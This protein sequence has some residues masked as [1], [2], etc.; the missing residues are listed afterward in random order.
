MQYN[1][2]FIFAVVSMLTLGIANF[3]Y[4]KSSQILGPVNATFYYYLFSFLI[5]TVVWLTFREKQF[6]SKFSY[7]DL[8]WPL[9]IAIFLFSSVLSF[10]YSV[11]YIN[12]SVGSTIRSMS[13][14]VTIVLALLVYKEN[15]AVKDYI[16]TVLALAAV[17]LF[18]YDGSPP[19]GLGSK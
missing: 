13:F 10:N 11:K 6:N 14:L 5:A 2:G 4:K 9:I 18:A 19:A 8:I 17:V 12:V 7:Q 15:F 1:L 16:A 3:Y